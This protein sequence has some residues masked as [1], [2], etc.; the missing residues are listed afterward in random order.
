MDGHLGM[1]PL[2][3]RTNGKRMTRT[4]MHLFAALLLVGGFFI[5]AWAGYPLMPPP[6][7]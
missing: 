7:Y 3:D 5:S 2:R 6:S 1:P 4:R